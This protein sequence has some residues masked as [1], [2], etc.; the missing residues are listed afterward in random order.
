MST[1]YDE[2]AKV[3]IGEYISKRETIHQTEIYHQK[4]LIAAIKTRLNHANE[5]HDE[6]EAEHERKREVCLG[7]LRSNHAEI[8][9]LKIK[10]RQIKRQFNHYKAINY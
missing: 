5:E 7:S 4:D 1:T 3:A 6:Q 2:I 9:A 8:K 10:L